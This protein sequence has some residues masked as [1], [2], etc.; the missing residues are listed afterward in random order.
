MSPGLIFSCHNIIS[1]LWNV[2]FSVNLVLYFDG[3]LRKAPDPNKDI[4]SSTLSSKLLPF[5]TCS[6]A[7]LDGTDGGIIALAAKEVTADK[8][9]ITSADVEYEGLLLGLHCLFHVME[10]KPEFQRGNV[11]VRGD[12]KTVIDQ[13]K[14]RSHPRKQRLYHQS[15]QDIIRKLVDTHEVKLTFQH[16]QREYNELCDGMCSI[17]TTYLQ[18]RAI[19]NILVMLEAVKVDYVPVALPKNP[20]K[21]ALSID[22]PFARVIHEVSKISGHVPFS[23]RPYLLCEI[24]H[25]S[26][27]LGDQ[28]A[29]R[30]V[31]LA[32]HEISRQ[33]QQQRHNRREESCAFSQRLG[34]IGMKLCHGSMLAMNL[35]REAQKVAKILMHEFD[36]PCHAVTEED[37]KVFQSHFHFACETN[38]A[39]LIQNIQKLAPNEHEQYKLSQW[40]DYASLVI[41][42][43]GDTVESPWIIFDRD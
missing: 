20:K 16:V 7:I 6:S 28:V 21:R 4:V 33:L 36:E 13:L 18:D 26:H 8:P 10:E 41:K 22:T 39:A 27:G 42:S 31:G 24:Y 15:C 43:S 12:C 38:K 17:I 19:E 25:A 29:V 37:M 32:M 5:A 23:V 1:T 30:L 14:G 40:T 2:I 9:D 35:E 11:C 3:S 34:L